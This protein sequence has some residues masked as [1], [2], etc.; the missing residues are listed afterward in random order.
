MPLTCSIHHFY[1]QSTLL[2]LLFTIFTM[3][4]TEFYT[5]VLLAVG[6]TV[7]AVPAP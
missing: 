3:F 7:E 2:P 1:T 6:A 4:S 5:L